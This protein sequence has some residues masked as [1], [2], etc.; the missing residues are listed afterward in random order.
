MNYDDSPTGFQSRV[1]VTNCL[2]RPIIIG[3][4]IL[5]QPRETRKLPWYYD[6]QTLYF[7]VEFA[8]ADLAR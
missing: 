4:D 8:D 1:S 6:P 5:I 7:W 2:D 3:A